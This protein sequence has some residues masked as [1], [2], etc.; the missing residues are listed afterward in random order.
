MNLY[1]IKEPRYYVDYI[2]RMGEPYKYTINY[3]IIENTSVL[4]L[5]Q[6]I[7]DMCLTITDFDRT[8]YVSTVFTYISGNKYHEKT[9]LELKAIEGHIQ[10]ILD[11]K[12]DA[13]RLVRDNKK[14]DRKYS[15]SSR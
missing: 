15:Y 10:D 1:V 7:E 13:K 9:K 3:H 6:N 2:H 4:K 12:F 5:V 11:D 14:F 8:L